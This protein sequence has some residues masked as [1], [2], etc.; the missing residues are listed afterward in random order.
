MQMLTIVLAAAVP[1]KEIPH[2]KRSCHPQSA[3]SHYRSVPLAVCCR[4]VKGC[5]RW[6]GIR[7]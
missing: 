4:C 3:I 5:M 7:I 2:L 1:V 6:D